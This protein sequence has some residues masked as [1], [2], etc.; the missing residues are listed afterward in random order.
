MKNTRIEAPY[1]RVMPADTTTAEPTASAVR[2]AWALTDAEV[3]LFDEQG[4]LVL[5]Q[6]IPAPLL[7]LLR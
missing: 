4:F 2:S 3:D 1:R 6:Q 5:E 7:A